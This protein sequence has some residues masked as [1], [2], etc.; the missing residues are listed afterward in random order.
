MAFIYLVGIVTT[1]VF[2]T[3]GGWQLAFLGF[4]FPVTV[5]GFVL[6]WK[7]IPT[8]VPP[9]RSPRRAA[10][11]QGLKA[12]S[13]NRSAM[14]SLVGTVLAMSSMNFWAVFST[15]FWRQQF[16]VSR[17]FMS[18]FNIANTPCFAVGSL[19]CSRLSHRFGR[20][21]VTVL[22]VFFQGVSVYGV[23]T[24]TEVWLS[25]AFG[26]LSSFIGGIMITALT[27]YNLEQDPQYQGTMMSLSFMAT[28]M[29]GIVGGAV[30]GIMLLLFN[31]RVLGMT[32][33]TLGIIA[34][35]IFQCCTKNPTK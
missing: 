27:S 8:I 4:V 34:S 12:V 16:L 14:L 32:L 10:L 22:A 2:V 20:R 19:L 5:L 26:L 15:S 7:A 31:Y 23:S 1:N 25:L 21:L 11:F 9:K 13:G 3:V 33:G 17:D 6:A 29:G 28:N 18:W 24:A 35:L 30:G